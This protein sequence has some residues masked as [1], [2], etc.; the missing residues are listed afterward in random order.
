MTAAV[1]ST[2]VSS[3]QTPAADRPPRP[4]ASLLLVRDGP[5]GIEVLLMQR[6]E[7]GDHN[8][9]AWV[10]PGGLTDLADRPAAAHALGLDDPQASARL[11][12][13]AHGIDYYLAAVRECFEES[14]LLLTEG[15]LPDLALLTGWRGR[16]QQGEATLA[17][18]CETHGLRLALRE[19]HYLSH[20]LTPPGRVKRF[21][22]RFFLAPAPHGQQAAPDGSETTSCRWLRPADALS[23][24]AGLKLMTPTRSNLA[25]VGRHPDV[26][27]LMAWAR[28]PRAVALTMPCM[29]RS[30]QGE[31]PVP[32]GEP[33]YAELL[34]LD[35]ER[36]G[37]AW[38]ELVPGRAMRLSPRVIRLTAGNGSVMTGP[39]TNTYLVGPPDEGWRASLGDDAAGRSTPLH[40]N[41]SG[42]AVI[43]PGPPD[44][45]HVEAI[46]AAAPGPIRWIFATHTHLDHSPAAVMLQA[47][48]GAQ[49][50]GRVADHAQWQDPHFAPTRHLQG[51]EALVLHDSPQGRSTL[52]VIHTPGHASN[53]LCFL[54][55][56][57]QMLFTGDH[58]MQGSTVVINPPDGDMA[59]YLQSL[60]ALMEQTLCWLAPGH[61]FLI[62]QPAEAMR[63]IVAHRLRREA[64]VLDAVRAA[65][66]RTGRRPAAQR[67]CRCAPPV[68]WHGPAVSDGTP[69][70]A[71]G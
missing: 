38:A 47:R 27:S 17:A 50:L 34:H 35:P 52:R 57:E 69:P 4:A 3:V 26:A 48:T 41:E 28:Q 33:A 59:A 63:A 31:R 54:L 19:L 29:G 37:H 61:G 18:L 11:N 70:E 24:G 66:P 20:W 36:R 16:L 30:L 25:I 15:P 53:H 44:A 10:F 8:S 60:R 21:D 14:G 67:L 40:L 39:G 12:L 22:T 9:G 46:L 49:V 43:D 5:Q 6:A 45:A 7:R 55:D 71:R 1:P 42:W 58:V 65:G 51:G 13:P 62:D 32:P 2:V 68:A 64:R 23:P 56:E